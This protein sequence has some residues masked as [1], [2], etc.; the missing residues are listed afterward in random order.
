MSEIELSATRPDVIEHDTKRSGAVTDAT[1]SATTT[2]AS[3]A[4]EAYEASEGKPYWKVAPLHRRQ[5]KLLALAWAGL[6]AIYVVIGLAIVHWWEP[7]AFGEADARL[8]EWL[9][10]HRTDGRNHLAERASALSD[11]ETKIGLLLLTLPLM[12]WMYRRWHDWTLL[13][14]GL[15][16]EVSVFFTTSKIVRRDRPAVEQLDTAPTFSWPSGH[17]AACVVFYVGLAVIVYANTR[18]KLSRGVFTAIAIAAPLVVT[19]SRLYLGMHYLTDAIG[20]IAL[21]LITLFVVHRLIV[22]ARDGVPLSEPVPQ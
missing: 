3:E 10:G 16:F 21:G 5:F 17:I 7:S 2:E 6:T 1:Q 18:S 12:L 13:A 20:G 14:V 19:A 15:L 8:N 11:T 4:T 22:Q 9:D